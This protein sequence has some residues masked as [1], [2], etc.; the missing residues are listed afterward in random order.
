MKSRLRTFVFIVTAT[1][2]LAALVWVAPAFSDEI[3]D[4]KSASQ[5]TGADAESAKGASSDTDIIPRQKA[6]QAVANLIDRHIVVWEISRSALAPGSCVT[7]NG[8]IGG[9]ANRTLARAG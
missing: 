4:G 2:V 7:S 6:A 5:S 1:S 9:E 8:R 3:D